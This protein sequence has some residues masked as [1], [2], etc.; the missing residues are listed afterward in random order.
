MEVTINGEG[1]LRIRLIDPKGRT[2]MEQKI[3]ASGSSTVQAKTL[4]PL[5]L[6]VANCKV[7]LAPV[8]AYQSNPHQVVK[9]DGQQP[10]KFT[11]TQSRRIGCS[12]RLAQR[13]AKGHARA[14]A[15][16]ELDLPK[17]PVKDRTS[18]STKRRTS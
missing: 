14:L 18:S 11:L 10:A 13:A 2:M 5:E 6:N 3:A 15:P 17:L 8:L 7:P 12:P 1:E 4:L 16:A 9:F